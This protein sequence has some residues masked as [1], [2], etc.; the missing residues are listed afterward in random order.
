MLMC[1][2]VHPVVAAVC[3]SFHGKTICTILEICLPLKHS[4]AFSLSLVLLACWYSRLKSLLL[5]NIHAVVDHL[6]I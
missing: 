4:I 3:G 5:Y 2:L 6:E 1:S